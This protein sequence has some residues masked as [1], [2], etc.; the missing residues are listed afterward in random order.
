MLAFG[1][2]G[3]F[4]PG[5]DEAAREV[6]GGAGAG[7]LG[8]RDCGCCKPECGCAAASAQSAHSAAAMSFIRPLSRGL[9]VGA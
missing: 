6:V 4:L 7:D 5:A 3:E 9:T 1:R 8:M 2:H